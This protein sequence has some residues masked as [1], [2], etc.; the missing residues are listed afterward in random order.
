M[1]L[2]TERRLPAREKRLFTFSAYQGTTASLLEEFE[3]TEKRSMIR[4]LSQASSDD[5]LEA[6]R[7]LVPLQGAAVVV[8]GALGCAVGA[9]FVAES[10]WYS[11]NLHERDTILG[12]DAKLR[13]TLIRAYREQK[14]AVL[15]ILGTPVVA[16]NNDD[17]NSVIMELE[18]ELSLPLIFIES[19][20]FKS[21]IAI[22]GIDLALHG[23]GRYFA[24]TK[25]TRTDTQ[26]AGENT[27]N[28][29][30]TNENK[31]GI[32]SLVK[33]LESLGAGVQAAPHFVPL[34]EVSKIGNAH[35]SIAINDSRAGIFL[36]GLEEESGVPAVKSETPLG[37][38]S[39]SAWLLAA[40]KALGVEDK[41]RALVEAELEKWKIIAAEKP[42]AGA[43][44]F[45]QL[46]AEEAAEAALFLKELGA[47]ITG[48]SADSVDETNIPTLKRLSQETFIH[49]GHEQSFELANIFSKDKPDFFIARNAVWAASYGVLPVPVKDQILYG[50]EG[51]AEL[52]QSIQKARR[53]RR[54]AAYLT[55]H[56]RPLYKDTWL[57][58]S[59]N[60]YIKVEVK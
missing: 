42:L 40:G 58:K 24:A 27:I 1:S 55:A 48:I 22:N 52:L 45:I 57:K 9:D 44:I 16:I 14:P 36:R 32:A 6:L 56:A 60:W 5:I 23:I 34:H 28:L 38:S 33:L 43:R 2:F 10:S 11:T 37:P 8:H 4:T 35:A 51:A 20:G 7:M 18:E 46:G 3:K 49:V 15:F 30:S 17:V 50:Y 59:S 21:R 12:G 39:S 19:D 25:K 13:E 31:R 47:S 26:S 29:I 41:A 53:G 54:F